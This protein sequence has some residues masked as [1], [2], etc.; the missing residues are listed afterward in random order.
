VPI[1]AAT[2]AVGW[3]RVVAPQGAVVRAGVELRSKVAGELAAGERVEA[4]APPR[5][6]QQGA[7]RLRLRAPSSGLVGWASVE[8]DEGAPLLV[9]EAAAAGIVGGKL[10]KT[11]KIRYTGSSSLP[12]LAIAEPPAGRTSPLSL[13]ASPLAHP[14]GGPPAA[15]CVSMSMPNL[16]GRVPPGSNGMRPTATITAAD[17]APPAG[18]A[19]SNDVGT[20]LPDGGG[21]DDFG[22]F[23]GAEEVDF[24]AEFD[25]A[26][27]EPAAAVGP[28]LLVGHGRPMAMQA[29]Y[30][31][32]GQGYAPQPVAYGFGLQPQRLPTS[33]LGRWQ[34][35]PG[36]SPPASPAQHTQ[37]TQQQTQQAQ[38]LDDL[39][40]S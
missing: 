20:L 37:Q 12:Q 31:R 22:E 8:T 10:Q 24:E 27:E 25:S 29:Q 40:W 2:V 14:P 11:Q 13:P 33:A 6:N 26:F 30:C 32:T 38:P 35:F 39:I 7:W 19:R 4:L 5:Q 28:P 3:W 34:Q 16:A 18:R 1:D 23:G 17:K 15:L 9:E 21:G 36:Q